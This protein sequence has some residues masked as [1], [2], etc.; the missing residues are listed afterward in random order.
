MF[1][2]DD[3]E[4]THEDNTTNFILALFPTAKQ[5][6]DIVMI[7]YG[8]QS[9]WRWLRKG[10]MSLGPRINYFCVRVCAQH[11]QDDMIC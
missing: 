6:A 10:R 2:D 5:S 9:Y 1:I 7:Y 11:Q 4:S 8:H 3:Q